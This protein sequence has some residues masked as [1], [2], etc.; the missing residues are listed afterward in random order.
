MR[1]LCCDSSWVLTEEHRMTMQQITKQ[2][3]FFTSDI[4]VQQNYHLKDISSNKSMSVPTVHNCLSD[5]N[6]KI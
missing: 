2:T 4:L 1:T 5:Q 3:F 6:C